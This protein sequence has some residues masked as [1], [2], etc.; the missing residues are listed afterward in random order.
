MGEEAEHQRAGALPGEGVAH[1]AARAVEH[2]RALEEAAHGLRFAG[3]HLGP[4]VGGHVRVVAGD[5]VEGGV[6]IGGV[7]KGHGRQLHGHRPAPRPGQERLELL[8]GELPGG[9]LGHQSSRLVGGEGQVRLLQAGGLA[10]ATAAL[11]ARRLAGAPG[12]DQVEAGR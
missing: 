5:R 9:H 4:E 12:D 11:E 1:R 7:T 3:Q 8:A 2:G 6:G 10:T